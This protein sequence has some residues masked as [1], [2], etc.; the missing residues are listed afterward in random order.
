[1]TTANSLRVTVLPGDGIGREVTESG[2]GILKQAAA[3][4]GIA[5]EICEEAIGGDALD[6]LGVPLTDEAVKTCRSSDAVLLG[7]VG[8]PKWDANPPELRPEKGLLKI[9]K[10]LGLYGNLRPVRQYSCLLEASTLKKDIVRGVDLVVVRELT[11]GLYFGEPRGITGPSGSERGYNTMAYERFEVERIARKAFDL[12]RLRRRN[13]TSVDK[14]NVL[15]VSR[16][17]RQVVE[18]VAAGYPDVTLCHQYVDN[19]AMQLVLR[20]TQFDVILTENTFGDILSDIGGVLTGS[21]GT[22]PSASVGDGPALYE[23]VHGSAPDIA[24]LGLANPIGAICCVGMMFEISLGRPDV[25]A[26]IT[27]SVEQALEAGFRTKDLCG[28]G[29]RSSSTS[30][31][32]AAVQERLAAELAVQGVTAP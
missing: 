7:A 31:F 29:P 1:M 22:L 30:E 10:S 3:A 32:T 18:E 17:W 23:P 11:G 25:A 4:V 28:G 26:A 15:E 13:V 14:A 16:L 2:L 19:C 20:P 24:G 27:R 21:I 6:R 12:A 5:L 9:R 8:G